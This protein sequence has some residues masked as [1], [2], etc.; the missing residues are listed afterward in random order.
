MLMSWLTS[1]QHLRSNNFPATFLSRN[2]FS[3]T[4]H[5]VVACLA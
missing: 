3:N 5:F 1:R 2:V 4:Q